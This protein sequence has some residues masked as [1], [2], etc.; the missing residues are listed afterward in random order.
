[1][2]TIFGAVKLGKILGVSR[3]TVY[4]YCKQGMPYIQRGGKR[5]FELDKVMEWVK[6][7]N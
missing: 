4:N 2:N 1:M 7:E 5:I 6:K 3:H